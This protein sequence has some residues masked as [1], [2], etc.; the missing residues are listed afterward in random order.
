M[1]KGLRG[2]DGPRP[3]RHCRFAIGFHEGILFNR[4]S[5]SNEW[6]FHVIV[7]SLIIVV[8]NILSCFLVLLD[9]PQGADKRDAPPKGE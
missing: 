3:I 9:V 5:Q 2:V 4:Y 1:N 6:W 8:K 7:A